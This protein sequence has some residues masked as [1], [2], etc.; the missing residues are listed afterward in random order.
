MGENDAL[1]AAFE[2]VT[3][4]LSMGTDLSQGLKVEHLS[5]N[6]PEARVADT[7]VVTREAGRLVPVLAPAIL[8]NGPLVASASAYMTPEYTLVRL[9]KMQQ[10]A[11]QIEGAAVPSAKGWNGALA[12][13]F[14]TIPLG[15]RLRD[16]KVESVLF[17][18]PTWLGVELLK[19]GIKPD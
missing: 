17:P 14:G 15:L 3:A 7:R 18:P 13:K 12:G 4:K 19:A 9:K 11:A 6:L 5:A 1:V 2:N 16:G 10:G 8:G